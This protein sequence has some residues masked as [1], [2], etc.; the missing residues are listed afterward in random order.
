M[1]IPLIVPFI[2][3]YPLSSLFDRRRTE[4]YLLEAMGKKRSHVSKAFLVEGILVCICAFITVILL[5]YPA[6]FFFKTV[7][8]YCKIPL[9]FEYSALSAPTLVLAAVF[10]CISA[11]LSFAICFLS[12]MT[13]RR[14]NRKAGR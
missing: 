4:L 8:D 5:C 13:R 11:A 14:K 1:I 10:S 12:T 6:M 2:W 3:Y 7:C 9:E